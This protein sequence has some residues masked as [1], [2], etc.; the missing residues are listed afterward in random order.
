MAL[1]VQSAT[2]NSIF[3]HLHMENTTKRYWKGVEELRNDAQFVKNANSEFTNV[4]SEEDLLGK[5]P[6]RRDFL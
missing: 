3:I 6:Q 1:N 5:D 4:N 2:T